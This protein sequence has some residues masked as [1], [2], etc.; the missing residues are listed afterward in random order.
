MLVERV[1]AHWDQHGWANQSDFEK[2]VAALAPTAV[3]AR[4][5]R[6]DVDLASDELERVT[7]RQIRLTN[8]QLEILS[9]L[10]EDLSNAEIADRLSITPKT[11]EHHVGAVLA[12][13][14]VSSRKAAVE[15]ARS[16]W[17]LPTARP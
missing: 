4:T 5:L 15:V 1:M 14:D 8:R 16:Q 3:V 13:L 10:A 7:R 11:A 17:L 2:A 6:Y 9:L 12:K